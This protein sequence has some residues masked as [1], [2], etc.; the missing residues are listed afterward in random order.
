MLL[1]GN[2]SKVLIFMR[3]TKFFYFYFKMNYKKLEIVVEMKG[4]I[5]KNT[6]S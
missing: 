3:L 2:M 6:G 5:Q 1:F 4:V